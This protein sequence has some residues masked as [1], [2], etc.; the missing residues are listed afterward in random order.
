MA[1]IKYNNV[2]KVV[3]ES[4]VKKPTVYIESTIPSYLVSRPSKDILKLAHQKV[5]KEWWKIAHNIYVLYI[6]TVVIDEI[7]IGDKALAKKRID[8]LAGIPILA[9]D[10]NVEKLTTIYIKELKLPERALRDASHL[11]IAITHKMDYLV[12]W[13]STHIAN[14][15]VRKKLG[16]INAKLELETPMICTP[17]ELIYMAD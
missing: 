5:T 6:S 9:V 8:I 14:E 4:V 10:E 15:H 2:D 11:A 3:G 7:T 17:E 16:K 1:K 13:N 12:T